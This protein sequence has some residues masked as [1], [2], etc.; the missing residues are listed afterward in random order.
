MN[1][2]P[3]GRFGDIEHHAVGIRLDRR[4]VR[5]AVAAIAFAICAEQVPGHSVFI[6]RDVPAEGDDSRQIF[7]QAGQRDSYRIAAFQAVDVY[8]FAQR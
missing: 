4:A 1:G 2:L 7:H 3:V 6:Q 5:Q 8:G